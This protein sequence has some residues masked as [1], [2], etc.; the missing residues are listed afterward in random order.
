MYTQ[1]RDDETKGA[2]VTDVS[3][4]NAYT[5]RTTRVVSRPRD[6]ETQ[7]FACVLCCIAHSLAFIQ[8]GGEKERQLLITIIMD[9]SLKRWR[10]AEA[11][12]PE[13]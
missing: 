4:L 3:D 8:K 1:K 10:M 13:E 6:T 9:G 2:Q 11:R 12:R 7:C 5:L